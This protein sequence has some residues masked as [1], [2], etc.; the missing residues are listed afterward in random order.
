MASRDRSRFE[1]GIA[2]P[3]ERD[4]NVGVASTNREREAMMSVTDRYIV[5]ERSTGLERLG[6]VVYDDEHLYYGNGQLLH[7]PLVTIRPRSQSAK[8]P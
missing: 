6:W 5:S 7:V 3:A 4:D 8:C 1:I 2:N